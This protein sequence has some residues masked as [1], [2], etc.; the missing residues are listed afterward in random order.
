MLNWPQ[1]ID[2]VQAAHLTGERYVCCCHTPCKKRY[3]L[4]NDFP[5]LIPFSTFLPFSCLV[6]IFM[7]PYSLPSG[8]SMQMNF[9]KLHL[10]DLLPPYYFSFFL[11]NLSQLISPP[12]DSLQRCD[13]W[14]WQC[15]ERYDFLDGT[16]TCFFFATLFSNLIFNTAESGKMHQ[17]TFQRRQCKLGRWLSF[18]TT[19]Q[20]L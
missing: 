14:M 17:M 20:F 18:F 3:G 12:T 8:C 2:H 13:L 1:C 10:E 5:W 7:P 11:L 19:F 6:Y 4:S 15:Q 9:A 16:F